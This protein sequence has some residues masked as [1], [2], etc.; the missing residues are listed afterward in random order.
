[1]IALVRSE[2][3]K[4][5]TTR[6]WYA[7]LVVIV[8]LDGISVAAAI[9][10]TDDARRGDLDFQVDFIEAAGFAALLAIILGITAVT[11]EFRHG[12]ITPTL[13]AEPVRER[14]LAAKAV[15]VTLV[16]LL[17]DVIALA[18]I[19][20]V[21]LIWLS[22][23]G[24]DIHLASGD[25]GTLAAQTLLGAVL[26]GLMGVAVGSLVQSQVAALVGTLIWIF[27]AESLLWGLFALLDVD[28]A[29]SYL[30]FQSLD[31]A[32]GTA[33][34]NLLSYG[35]AVAVASGWIVLIGAAGTLRTRRRDIT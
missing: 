22:L 13:L 32:D 6:G 2:L 5:R 20:A 19:A 15:A 8:L 21:A 24:A 26:W 14:V 3:L 7:Y 30:P 28:G 17:F 12:T 29:V 9:G 27:V 10:S 25:V 31:G 34:E 4:V 1:V 18:V 35:P 23:L 33:G 16:S 11:T